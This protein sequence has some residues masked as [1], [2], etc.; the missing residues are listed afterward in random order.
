MPRESWEVGYPF[1]P[2]IL[3]LSPSFCLPWIKWARKVSEHCGLQNLVP[4]RSRLRT[5]N[6][7]GLCT[8]FQ[9]ASFVVESEYYGPQSPK[10]FPWACLTTPGNPARSGRWP[11]AA[12]L[13]H[14]VCYPL[15]FSAF[16]YFLSRFLYTFAVEGCALWPTRPTIQEG[17]GKTVNLKNWSFVGLD[18]SPLGQ[19]W[20]PCG[21][22][23]IDICHQ[24]SDRSS[25]GRLLKWAASSFRYLFRTEVGTVGLR[26]SL[27]G[28]LPMWWETLLLA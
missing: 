27:F 24:L 22:K 19:A 14:K 3:L 28:E 1:E 2:K 20:C 7:C 11:Y 6:F 13:I 18:K 12:R 10:G 15:L 8:S 5:T 26:I 23:W 21:W 25:Y 17:E 9:S 4:F 16:L